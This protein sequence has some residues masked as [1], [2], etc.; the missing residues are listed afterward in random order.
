MSDDDSHG[1]RRRNMPALIFK[2]FWQMGEMFK[3]VKKVIKKKG[4]YALLIGAN[5]TTL[6]DIEILIDTPRLLSSIAEAKGW[7]IEETLSFETYQRFDVHKRNSIQNET[8][9]ILRNG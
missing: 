5:K 7:V 8:L 3:S 4:K 1:F 6:K 9:L 2:Y